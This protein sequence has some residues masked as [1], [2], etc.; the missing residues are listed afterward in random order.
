MGGY[1]PYHGTGKDQRENARKKLQKAKKKAAA[2][3]ANLSAAAEAANLSAAA[4]AANPSRSSFDSVR[5]DR[6]FSLVFTFP[7]GR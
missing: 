2:E 3:A 1:T 4:A 7:L 5:L 6:L